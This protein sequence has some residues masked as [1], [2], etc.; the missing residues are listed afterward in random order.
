M[1]KFVIFEDADDL[2]G[3]GD[4]KG[5]T[6]EE[7]RFIPRLTPG[8]AKLAKLTNCPPESPLEGL[9]E[10]FTDP[11]LPVEKLE[12]PEPYAKEEPVLLLKSE[13]L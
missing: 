1:E 3:F 10:A 12:E 7:K 11:L 9:A 4:E 8:V 2:N 13:V 5:V 6:L